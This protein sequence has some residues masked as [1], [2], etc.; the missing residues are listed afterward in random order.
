MGIAGVHFEKGG[1]FYEKSFYC[2]AVTVTAL[3][4]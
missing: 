4:M 1:Y 3:R 2:N